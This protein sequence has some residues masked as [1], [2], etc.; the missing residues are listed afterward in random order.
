[1]DDLIDIPVKENEY[2]IIRFANFLRGVFALV[3]VDTPTLR[4]A[5]RALGHLARAGGPMTADF[6][7]FE[8][9][10]ALEWLQGGDRYEARRHSAVLVLRQLADHAPTLFY[11]HV[12]TFFSSIW[13]ALCDPK[14]EIRESAA[15]ALCSCLA[16]V[17]HRQSRYRA[18]WY[19]SIF[20]LAKTGV[21]RGSTAETIHGSLLTIGELLQNTGSFM[22]P[23]F[24][25]VCEL[26]LKY[27]QSKDRLV[28]RSV[29]SLLPRLASFMPHSFASEARSTSYL[30]ESLDHLLRALG[31]TNERAPAFLA[32]G[33]VALA[34][35]KVEGGIDVLKPHLPHIVKQIHDGLQKRKANAFCMEALVC[36][37]MLAHAV[38]DA[39][40]DAMHDL[41]PSMFNAG[42]NP[43]LTEALSSVVH[44]VPSLLP[45]VQERLLHEISNTLAGTAF[46]FPGSTAAPTMPAAPVGKAR[47]SSSAA[48]Q[49]W[50][51]LAARRAGRG[52]TTGEE[53]TEVDH[54]RTQLALKTLSTF[55]FEGVQLL[56]FLRTTVASSYLSHDVPAIRR[57][58]ALTCSKLLLGPCGGG[59]PALLSNGPTVEMVAHV[60]E[61]LLMVGVAD[62]DADIRQCVLSSLEPRFDPLLAQADNLRFLCIALHDEVFATREAA[63]T[64]IGRLAHRNPA[65]VMPALR[66]TLIQ[67]LT[68]LEFSGADRSKQEAAMLLG[69][70]VRTAQTLVTP[71][72]AHVVLCRG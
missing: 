62:P 38:R 39:I 43:T 18:Q 28:R 37:S 60:L 19:N 47:Q 69:H 24:D 29:L 46:A 5:A 30:R 48:G 41:L 44:Y 72:V 68:E 34:V 42:L 20:K 45:L 31:N 40:K 50:N 8:V 6:V 54:R 12:P 17:R 58:A 25:N 51:V 59:A 33:R 9:K 63:I 65:Y 56:P 15:K 7:E 11:Q 36:V 14:Y 66:K 64:I 35:S 3:T 16:L 55:N 26:V 61:R 2:K 32:V 49:L 10:R 13:M 4:L 22:E 23:R 27:R 53:K 70:L 52:T 57:E 1:M 71:Y 21:G 67:L